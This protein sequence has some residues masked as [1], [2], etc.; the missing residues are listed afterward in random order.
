MRQITNKKKDPNF[1][2]EGL[3]FSE[4]EGKLILSFI[5]R[6]KL[7]DLI[8]TIEGACKSKKCNIYDSIN[9]LS[10]RDYAEKY[11]LKD[12]GGTLDDLRYDTSLYSIA[13]FLKENNNYKIYHS[14]DDFFVNENQLEKLKLYS[15][16]NVVCLNNGSH[17]GFLYRKE[18][19][20]AFKKDIVVT[21]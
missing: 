7:S 10:Y 16:S 15:P 14:L 17:L 1:K 12:V 20:E 8:F 21:N 11:L 13:G 4:E 18:F 6:Q 19:Q 3:P 9:N 5:M 2:F